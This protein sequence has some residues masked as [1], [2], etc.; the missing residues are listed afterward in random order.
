MAVFAL[1]DV[2]RRASGG[3]AGAQLAL[4]REYEAA[5]AREDALAWLRRAAAAGSIDAK[6]LLG[7]MLL[8]DTRLDPTEGI[9]LTMEAAQAGS[10]EAMHLFAVL[11]ASGRMGT[12]DWP[13]VLMFLQR[14]AEQ[15]FPLAQA[16]LALLADDAA[17]SGALA[18]GET[19]RPETWDRLRL[20]VDLAAWLRV[21]STRALRSDPRIGV[22]ESFASPALC[23]WLIERGRPHLKRARIDT[24]KTDTPIFSEEIGRAHV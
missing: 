24:L 20:A 19:P 18:Q 15:G 22:C 9:R 7:R 8:V 17:L 23:H 6:T 16:E 11:G 14:A 2:E 13:R 12:P 1:D 21:P 10:G 3:D 5:G 4:A